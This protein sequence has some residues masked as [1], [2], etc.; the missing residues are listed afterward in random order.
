MVLIFFDMIIENFEPRVFHFVT[1]AVGLHSTQFI[2]AMLVVA[3]GFG[4]H[5]FKQ[6]SKLFYGYSEVAFG[7]LSAVLV[8]TRINFVAAE[9]RSLS[10]A[11]YGTLVGCAYVVARGLNNISEAK[12]E[13]TA[14]VPA[15]ASAETN[16]H[17]QAEPKRSPA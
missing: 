4:A 16:S 2:V 14:P 17:Y 10:L 5:R 11:Q 3:A 7:V 12:Q 8:V 13:K 6:T 15:A 9:F 1:G